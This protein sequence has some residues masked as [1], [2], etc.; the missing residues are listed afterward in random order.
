MVLGQGEC[1][2]AVNPDP[3][4]CRPGRGA[5]LHQDVSCFDLAVRRR[6]FGRAFRSGAAPDASAI[7]AWIENCA[8][9]KPSDDHQ[10]RKRV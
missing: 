10:Q 7:R 2:P 4:R 9:A 5:W 6:A 8:Q 3:G 1:G